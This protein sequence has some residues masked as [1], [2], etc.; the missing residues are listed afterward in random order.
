MAEKKKKHPKVKL[1]L[2]P[3]NQHRG[4]YDF[5][6]LIEG[7]PAL[8]EFVS[9]NKFGDE[10]ID[11]FNPKSVK[12]LNKSLLKHFYKIDNWEIPEGYLCP[13][14]PG[15]ADYIHH[16]ADLLGY[17]NSQSEDREVPV[18][19]DIKCLDV[20]IGANCVYPI[21]G[22]IEYGWFFI[23]SEI[24]QKAIDAAN[25]NIE[26][27]DVIKDLVQVR[28]QKNPSDIFKGII[29][30]NEQFDITICNPPFHASAKEAAQASTRK[31]INLKGERVKE[32]VLNFGGQNTE[33]WTK[34]GEETFVRN[35]VIQSA[36]H[37]MQCFWFTTLISKKESLRGVY[38]ALNKVGA[39]EVKTIEMGQGNKISRIVAWTFL[40]KQQ[41]DYWVRS[42]WHF[43]Q[44]N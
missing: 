41:Q 20:G 22:A 26:N 7:T 35:I 19:N 16:I 34:G 23:G 17:S 42:R 1:E 36:K 8:K 21:M 37:A 27:N 11:F 25:K 18:G 10:S 28:L 14:I 9:L 4:R 31:L 12:A 44:E 6:T 13:P 38:R 40:T 33:L 24:D 5:K 39:R 32:K 15:R 3:R 29:R 2:H 30:A 43:E